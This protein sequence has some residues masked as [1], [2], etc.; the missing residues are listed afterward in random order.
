MHQIKKTFPLMGS[1]SQLGGGGL[2]SPYGEGGGD[3]LGLPPTPLTK[4]S[5]GA[6]ASCGIRGLYVHVHK[7]VLC[8]YG[9]AL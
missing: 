8:I 2:F 4:I 3:F 1:F 6:H 9:V 5:A 7:Y